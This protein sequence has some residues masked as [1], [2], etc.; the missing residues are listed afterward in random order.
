MA[1]PS[2]VFITYLLESNGPLTQNVSFG[3]SKSIHCNYIQRIETQES[4][5]GKTVTISFPDT[6][7]FRFMRDPYDITSSG[8]G[9]GWTA[10]KF[11]ILM[12]VVEG[13]GEEVRPLP[14]QW[15]KFD[16]TSSINNYSVWYNKAIP[17]EQLEISKFFITGTEYQNNTTYYNLDYLNYPTTDDDTNLQFGEEV[18]FYGNVKAKISAT[19]HAMT[20]NAVLPLN[21]FNTS[22]NPTWSAGDTVYITEVGIYDED[23]TLL[24]VGKM[25]VPIDKDSN[26]YRTI[27]FKLDF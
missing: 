19:I 25:N 16:K 21:Q 26:K 20:I 17:P 6:E 7:N 9:Y 23:G 18:F 4:I 22:Q 2:T 13:I 14:D 27:E 8:N 10:D 15:K 1:Q 24:G 11:Y 12:Q 5:S 3:Y